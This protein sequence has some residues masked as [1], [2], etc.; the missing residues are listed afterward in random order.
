MRLIQFGASWYN[1]PGTVERSRGRSPV[2]FCRWADLH[3]GA[4]KK[5]CRPGSQAIKRPSQNPAESKNISLQTTV[6]SLLLKSF[7]CSYKRLDVFFLSFPPLSDMLGLK[8]S[9]RDL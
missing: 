3:P 4:G 1:L 7:D 8:A 9:C 5:G 2:M 6:L